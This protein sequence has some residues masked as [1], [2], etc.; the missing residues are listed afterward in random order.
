MRV[1]VIVHGFPPSALG[2]TEIYAEAHARALL[3]QG[4]DVFVLTREADPARPEYAVRTEVR[5]GLRIASINNTFRDTRS[6]EETYCNTTIDAAAARLIDG[7]RPDVAHIHHLTCLSTTIVNRLAERGIPSVLTLH[8]YWLIC[9]RGQLLNTD[10]QVCDGPGHGSC[11][12]CVGECAGVHSLGFAAAP[13][14]RAIERTLPAHLAAQL[15][16]TARGMAALASSTTGGYRQSEARSEHM[17]EACAAITHFI[18]PSRAVRDRFVRFGVSSDRIT[19]SEYGIDLRPL[20]T[21]GRSPASRLRLGFV[22]SLMVS[23]APHLLLEAFEQLPREAATV[24]VHGAHAAYHGD[25]SYRACLEPLLKTPGVRAHGAIGRAALAHALSSLDVL[26]VPSVWPENSPLVIREAFAAGIPVVASRI[27]GIPEIVEDGRN[28]LLFDPGSV[29]DLA[30]VLN[31][32]VEEPALVEQLRAGIPAVR[33]IDD[34]VQE[35]R[36]LFK[37]LVSGRPS[38]RMRVSAV[39]LNYRTPDDTRLAVKSLLASNT[40]FHQVI[41]VNN[42][43]IHTAQDALRDVLPSIVYLHTGRNLGFSGGINVGIREALDGGADAVLLTNS[44]VFVPPDCVAR[45]EQA[46]VRSPNAGIAGPMVLARSDPGRI[47]SLGMAYV[48]G[49]GRMRHHGY[50]ERLRSLPPPNGDR[51]DGVSGC[52]MLVRRDVFDT[53]GLLDEEFF[54]S[55]EDLDFCLR[56]KRAGFATV[57]ARSA[58][59]YHEGSRSMGPDMPRRIFFATRNHLLLARRADPSAG[60]VAAFCRTSSILLLNVAHAV[61]SGGSSLPVRLTAVAR[62]ALDYTRGRFGSD[63]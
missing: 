58:T 11:D 5:D 54:F 20:R 31:R 17:R 6:F 25:D 44:D 37:A 53:I 29:E 51:V 12:R 7:F 40:K 61:R 1:L 48:P 63:V 41:V 27:G 62:G 26:V 23:K 14:V 22:G 42:D 60:P 4:D 49:T 36:T 59:V 24:D 46:L 13:A 43:E 33:S 2:G 8:D 47:A 39:V 35:T 18:A 52:L 32:L 30:R 16:R 3:E 56:A 15:H 50:G 19:V 28:G 38:G 9:H 57:L 10:C 21:V 55:F 45:L 34:D